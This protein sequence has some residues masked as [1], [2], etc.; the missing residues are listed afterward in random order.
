[1][2]PFLFFGDVDR[3]VQS[4]IAD[5]QETLKASMVLKAMSKS[6]YEVLLTPDTG[7]FE[8]RQAFVIDKRAVDLRATHCIFR[9]KEEISD[10]V[11]LGKDW[12][13]LFTDT[14]LSRDGLDI[15]RFWWIKVRGL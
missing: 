2:V 13:L 9:N 5:S 3:G 10:G 12:E 11:S 8:T 6:N 15:I 14:D 7:Q 1:M 4:V